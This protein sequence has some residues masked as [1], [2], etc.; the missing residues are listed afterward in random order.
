L[1]RLDLRQPG[2]A[3]RVW[4]TVHVAAALQGLA[5]RSAPRLYVVY[6]QDFGVDTDQF[7]LDWLRGEDGWLSRAEI[8]P[9]ADLEAAVRAFRDVTKGLVVYD[10]AVPAT[11]NAA[12]TVAGCEDL[13]P[14]R[15]DP[16]PGS[17]YDLLARRL[18]LPVRVGLVEPDGRSKFTGKGE[19]PDVGGPASGSAKCD[20][21]RWA[22]RRY[23]ESG[24]CDPGFAAYYIDSFW[25]RAPERGSCD[26][27][28]LSNHDYF[29]AHRAF[30]FDLSCW[31]DE[32]PNDDPGQPLGLD[33]KVLLDVLRALQGRA[34]GGMIK[35]G[36]FTPWPYKYTDAGGVGGR[37][38]G[39]PTEWELSRIVS[40]YD[41]YVEADAAGLSAM[42]NAS[43]FQHYPLDERYPQRAPRPTLETWKARGLVT[44]EGR[45]APRLF[46]G[47]YVGDYDAPSWLYKAV[48]AHFRDP[49]RGRVP[50]GW[51]FNPNLADR[52]APAM[53]YA[54]RRATEADF[55]IAGDSGAGYVNPRA[56]SHRPESGLPPALDVWAEHCARHYRRWDI[57]ITGFLLDG[58]AGASGD[59]EFAAYRA[60]SPDGMG[61]HFEPG[62]ALRAGVPTCP[63]RDLPDDVGQA[64]AL[65][66]R[67]DADRR[68]RPGFLWARSILK[69]PGWYAALSDRIRAER[70]EAQVEVVDPYTFFG[71]IRLQLEEGTKL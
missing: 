49:A 27:H 48:P 11:S 60:F 58:S 15:Y 25:I 52:V 43:F 5:N 4:D 47:H 38:G 9:L 2:N 14:V 6:C 56:L 28:T 70:P 41:A 67:A 20:V 50:L 55:F 39:V 16:E 29:I 21:H 23:L 10:P 24:K 32:A 66:L 22:V 63:E 57:S 64:A 36:G 65:I 12:S 18:K 59:A 62:P 17:T 8:R 33:R 53:A 46:L 34:K 3:R 1:R 68:G 51:A 7:W 40:Q 31:G 30:F 69:S 37:H 13:L 35:I 45:P 71:L 26:L 19:L 61:T 42:A 44:A 54:R